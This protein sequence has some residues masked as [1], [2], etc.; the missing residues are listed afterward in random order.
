MALIWKLAWRGPPTCHL[1]A[2]QLLMADV[3]WAFQWAASQWAMS[4]LQN[5][6]SEKRWRQRRARRNK[7]FSSSATCTC[8]P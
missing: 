5:Y 7:L 8:P 2:W 3:A 4:F 1:V 6:S